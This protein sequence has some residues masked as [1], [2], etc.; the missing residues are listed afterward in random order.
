MTHIHF[1]LTLLRP[2]SERVPRAVQACYR[3]PDGTVHLW[4]V[5]VEGDRAGSVIRVKSGH[6]M[7]VPEARA[8]SLV[9]HYEAP[10]DR[11]ERQ[12]ALVVVDG[13]T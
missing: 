7:L 13:G 5:I 2:L 9:I 1:H 10:P 12:I 3:L 4:P 11:E 6:D 8:R